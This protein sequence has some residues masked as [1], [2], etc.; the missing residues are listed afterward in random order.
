M[1][2]P[3][4]RRQFLAA[5]MGGAATLA[6]PRGAFAQ[7][8]SSALTATPLADGLVLITGAGANVVAAVDV[9]GL[10]LV[11]GGRKENAAALLDFVTGETGQSNVK[12]LLN[13]HWHPEQTGL[14]E[15]LGAQGKPIIAHENTRLWLQTEIEAA[16][17]TLI[18]APLPASAVPNETFYDE[19]ALPFADG[20][21]RYVYA[22]QAHTDGDLL[23][24]FPERNVIVAGGALKTDGWQHIDAWTGGWMGAGPARALNSVL[25]PTYGGMVGGLQTLLDMADDQTVIIPAEGPVANKA[26]IQAQFDM[27]AGIADKLREALFAALSPEEVL[28]EAPAAG[29]RPEWGS[30]DAFL[31]EAFKSLW[32]H[33]SPDS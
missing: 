2:K 21:A 15:T 25:I 12:A 28:G 22:L 18:H 4:H 7:A 27:Y 14:N 13:T 32:P 20:E 30:P 26:E 5:T 9:D 10:I 11:D 31:V 33:L 19:G 1:M 24:H 16:D 29:M 17:G 6:L 23:V 3:L 8:A